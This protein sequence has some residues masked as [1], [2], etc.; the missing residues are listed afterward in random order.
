M[1][2]AMLE[3]EPAAIDHK[4]LAGDE[5]G[6]VAGQ[7]GTGLQMLKMFASYRLTALAAPCA[8]APAS[9]RSPC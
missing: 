8:N 9:L 1:L 3:P 7:E 2:P 6:V 4:G 5:T